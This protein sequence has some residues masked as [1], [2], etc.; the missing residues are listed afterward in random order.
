MKYITC[1][2][3]CKHSKVQ[4]ILLRQYQ[5]QCKHW[6]NDSNHTDDQQCA[7]VRQVEKTPYTTRKEV[8][9][10]GY[11]QKCLV[12]EFMVKLPAHKNVK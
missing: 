8:L 10:L 1:Q 2:E 3:L 5:G 9:M 6:K 7:K 12:L 4:E 11:A